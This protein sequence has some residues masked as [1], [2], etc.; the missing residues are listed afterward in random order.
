MVENPHLFGTA[1]ITHRGLLRTGE[2]QSVVVSG[3]SGAG[4]TEATKILL[5]YYSELVDNTSQGDTSAAKSIESQVHRSNPVL[6]CFGNAKTIRND[7][8]SRFGKF[9]QISFRAENLYKIRKVEISHYLLEKCRLIT[10]HPNERNFHI[11]YALLF[12]GN[13]ID[14]FNR[15]G[16]DDPSIF[17]RIMG[18]DVADPEIERETLEQ[19]VESMKLVGF[20]S[21]DI[22]TIFTTVAAILHL[23]RV[24]FVDIDSARCHKDSPL[25]ALLDEEPLLKAAELMEIHPDNL[26]NLLL[27]GQVRDPTGSGVNIST[28]RDAAQASLLRDSVIKEIYSRIF[29]HIVSVVNRTLQEEWRLVSRCSSRNSDRSKRDIVK[30]CSAPIGL[31]DIYGF[32]VFEG[33]NSFE[34]LCINYANEKLQQ[35]FNHHVL[36]LEQKLYLSEGIDWSSIPF[37]DNQSIIDALETKPKGLFCLLDTATLAPAGEDNYI[38]NSIAMDQTNPVLSIPS[39]KNLKK[40]SI[41]INHYAGIVE[42][43]VDG[44][45]Y[46]NQDRLS[47]ECANFFAMQSQS[48]LLLEM[49]AQTGTCP[50]AAA[51]P[52]SL[53]STVS[54]EFR[55]QMTKLM[56]SLTQTT[57]VY[58][59][60]IKPNG[61]KR[62]REFDSIDVLRQLGYAGLLEGIRIRN[63]GYG[64]RYPFEAFLRRYGRLNWTVWKSWNGLG[65]HKPVQKQKNLCELLL[66]S[67]EVEAKDWILGL[68]KVFLRE[69][70]QI[71]ME[72][73][74]S[75]ICVRSAVK[76]QEMARRVQAMKQLATKRCAVLTIQRQFRYRC[77]RINLFKSLRAR[78]FRM[79]GAAKLIQRHW[80][81]W[82]I[83]AEAIEISPANETVV[84]DYDVQSEPAN[85]PKPLKLIQRTGAGRPHL[86]YTAVDAAHYVQDQG[87]FTKRSGSVLSYHTPQMLSIGS[88][89]P[90]RFSGNRTGDP[91]SSAN[92]MVQGT[93]MSTMIHGP[94]FGQTQHNV[95]SVME[96]MLLMFNNLRDQESGRNQMQVQDLLARNSLLLEEIEDLK[97]TEAALRTHA[98][99]LSLGVNLVSSAIK[100]LHE[101][102]ITHG[103]SEDSSELK[104]LIL[105]LCNR[106]RRDLSIALGQPEEEEP[107]ETLL[108]NRSST[109]T[110]LGTEN[111]PKEAERHSAEQRA[112]C[113]HP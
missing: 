85:I 104:G 93:P 107:Y 91:N 21:T 80:R 67:A 58:V 41:L 31:L 102:A 5:K 71:K 52:T 113:S 40:S 43:T 4:K 45:V 33:R 16:L 73:E 105:S 70:V 24:Q 59:R 23:S 25:A 10:Q 19:L 46:K 96:G 36:D 98:Q 44:W 12:G 77:W 20:T 1:Q 2:P 54:L 47:K 17:P 110:R 53:K 95:S 88:Q 14:I 27:W 81:S 49:F 13:H 15:L 8:S 29:E 37:I 57:P 92:R 99:K 61:N 106:A 39:A 9:I 55:N 90:Q 78:R 30:K 111:R 18:N 79:T 3:E 94:C 101:A 109:S 82:K 35:H 66:K 63:C 11:F 6:E 50:N 26:C 69:E 65:H 64:V 86:D 100:A 62:A 75:L 32:E 112:K 22:N 87:N 34:Q 56:N 89:S 74:R 48:P 108:T 42:Y 28:K 51:K 83:Q 38:V 103:A 84:L 60:C 7:N 76:I 68:T 97:S 72:A